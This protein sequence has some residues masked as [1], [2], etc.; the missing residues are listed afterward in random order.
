M[1]CSIRRIEVPWSLRIDEQQL[2][3]RRAFARVQA[4]GGLVEA[5]QRGLGA[6]RARD[7]EPPL[8]AI[9]QIAGGV[10]GA[11]EQA[12][13]IE[14]ELGEIDRA[15]LGRRD[16]PARRSGRGRSGPRP[17]SARC[18]APPSGSPARSCRETAGCSG[19][20]GRPW[21]AWRCG[22]R[23]AAPAR[24]S[25]ASSRVSRMAAAG[26]LVEAGDAV[27]HGG[28]AGAVRSDQRG[29]LACGRRRRRDR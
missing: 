5:E 15:L 14:P 19:R 17:A 20:C 25:A 13:A 8:V 2:A 28:L 10:V 7:L 22:N 18:A 26:R 29:D 9:G 27:E 21:P 24:Y 12:D 16:R 4:G 1:S 11:V 23:S 3:Q 6:H